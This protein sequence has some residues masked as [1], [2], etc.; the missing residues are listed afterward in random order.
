MEQRCQLC[1]G[2]PLHDV[3]QHYS[4]PLRLGFLQNIQLQYGVVHIGAHRRH[5]LRAENVP[6][7][8]LDESASRSQAGQAGLYEALA[9]EA[10]EHHV[11]ALASGGFQDFPAESG[12]AAIEYVLDAKGAKIRLLWSAGGGEYLRTG[13]RAPTVWPPV[14][15][16]PQ[17]RE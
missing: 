10:V 14:P 4:H 16:R 9:G 7:G 3:A 6:S 1:G 2:D 15:P 11:D 12:L 17:R 8:Q 5:F 13:P